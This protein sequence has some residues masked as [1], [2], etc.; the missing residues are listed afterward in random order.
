V[1]ERLTRNTRRVRHLASSFCTAT[2]RSLVL[3]RAAVRDRRGRHPSGRSLTDIT[4]AKVADALAG[5]P[6]GCCSSICSTARSSG[7][8]AVRT[9]LWCSSSV[10]TRFGVKQPGTGDRGSPARRGRRLRSVSRPDAVDPARVH[11]ARLGDE[12]TVCFETSRMERRAWRN[13][14]SRRRWPSMSKGT[15]SSRRPPSSHHQHDRCP[16]EDVLQAIALHRAKA[17]GGAL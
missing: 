15:G 2:V 7:P 11:A 17:D 4:E 3:R 16:P 9:G 14:C 5:L 6:N 12:F 8:S 10:S 13:G 1:K